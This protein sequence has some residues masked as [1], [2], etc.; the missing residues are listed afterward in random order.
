[1]EDFKLMLDLHLEGDRQGPGSEAMTLR[2]LELSGLDPNAS[3]RVADIGC[4]SG[5]STL[6]LA[7]HTQWQIIAVDFFPVFLEKLSRQAQQQGVGDQIE[8][9][10]G[11]MNQLPFAEAQFDLIW[12]EG[13][14][15]NMGFEKGIAEWGRFLK[16]GGILAVSEIAWLTEERPDELTAFWDGEYPEIGTIGEKI[17]VLE[18]QGYSSLA[19]FVLPP[20]CWIQ[21][22]YLPTQERIP[23]F[24]ERHNNSVAAQ[25]LVA[26]ENE[27]RA[28][29]VANQAFYSYGFFLAQR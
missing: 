9:M 27:E 6:A 18:Q 23:S 22:Y 15:Y 14:I 16:P 25:E 19:H 4:G 12:S 28:L 17:R 2:A 1:M 29:Y 10:A 8:A 5:A 7:R 13:A 20:A 11:D 3:L 24:L 26:M 21:E